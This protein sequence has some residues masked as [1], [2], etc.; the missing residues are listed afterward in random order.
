MWDN[1]SETAFI[2]LL[3]VLSDLRAESSCSF[4]S[5]SSILC[6]LFKLLLSLEM[7]LAAHQDFFPSGFF[8]IHFPVA[9]LGMI[10]STS[11]C[12]PW[13]GCFSCSPS[14]CS[15]PGPPSSF[16]PLNMSVTVSLLS[17]LF[18]LAI[19]HNFRMPDTSLKIGPNHCLALLSQAPL[20]RWLAG[21]SAWMSHWQ[22]KL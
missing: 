10:I 16:C 5:T 21:L 17:T 1:I 7:A 3:E 22:L 8:L 13:C 11:F 14:E 19:L 18:H 2:S 20:S 6:L 4:T 9:F 12:G 15:F